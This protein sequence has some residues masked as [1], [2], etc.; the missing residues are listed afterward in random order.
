MENSTK[1]RSRWSE[2]SKSCAPTG[3]AEWAIAGRASCSEVL[4]F[5]E[6]KNPLVHR[7]TGSGR[8][9]EVVDFRKHQVAFASFL[10]EDAERMFSEL[11]NHDVSVVR[12]GMWV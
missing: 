4:Y 3:S 8:D 7:S 12:F 5:L 9:P 2:N 1:G 11:R 10:F 6:P